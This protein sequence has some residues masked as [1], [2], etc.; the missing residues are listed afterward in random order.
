MEI[1]VVV[2][3]AQTTFGVVENILAVELVQASIFGIVILLL[4]L[5]R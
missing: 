2:Q 1:F 3:F 5:L 4:R